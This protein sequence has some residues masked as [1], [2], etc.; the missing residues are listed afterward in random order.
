MSEQRFVLVVSHTR[1]DDALVAA[2]D[3][4]E[5]LLTFGITPVMTSAELA[6]HQS[7]GARQAIPSTALGA[8][9][10]L[11]VG[12]AVA[13]LELAMVL[14][15]DGTILKAAEIVRDA[16]VP[17]MGINLG[18]VGI[19][20]FLPTAGHWE[21]SREASTNAD[22]DQ[23]KQGIKHF[24]PIVLCHRV[25]QLSRFFTDQFKIQIKLLGIP[26]T[27]SLITSPHKLSLVN[28]YIHWYSPF[29]F[30]L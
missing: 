4:C 26:I 25:E 27:D 6:E 15:G 30:T 29:M 2:Q 24:R 18:H 11:G 19:H 21:A 8:I 22:H 14:G 20:H 7:F 17:L 12:C 23:V 9:A 1:R 10:E 5:Q 16:E 3:A 13:D 28:K